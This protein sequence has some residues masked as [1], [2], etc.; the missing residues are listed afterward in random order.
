MRLPSHTATRSTVRNRS[1]AVPLYAALAA[2]AVLSACSS[3]SAWRS[4]S[5]MTSDRTGGKVAAAPASQAGTGTQGRTA[6][7]PA[8]GAQP[9]SA[10]GT[11]SS[12][13]QQQTTPPQR[14]AASAQAGDGGQAAHA[15]GEAETGGAGSRATGAAGASSQSADATTPGS[16]PEI[17]QANG[18]GAGGSAVSGDQSAEGAGGREALAS[19]DAARSDP[20]LAGSSLSGAQGS[21]HGNAAASAAGETG[22]GASATVTDDAA[23]GT[24]PAVQ[25]TEG[26]SGATAAGAAGETASGSTGA[27]LDPATTAATSP[28]TSGASEGGSALSREHA[29]QQDGGEARQDEIII[30]MVEAPGKKATPT[31]TV[32]PQTLGGML[33]LTLGVE[34]E[35]EF[36]FDK[37][38]V[39]DQVRVV[40]DE[41]A[42]KLKT[43]DYDRL[44]IIGHT[45]RIGTE[46]YNQ[47]L[48]ERR[49]WAVAR[50]L[51]E[52]GV[53]ANKVLVEGR[54]M[55]EPVTA[56]H[57]CE[58]LPREE[59]IACLQKD[60]RVVI[61]A[62]IRRVDVNVH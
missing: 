59:A 17:T 58:G 52:Q 42:S 61:S 2:A 37:A 31:E 4:S 22:T 8:A 50:Y 23:R 1:A 49:A 57:I 43:A 20:G 18:A 38:I 3:S 27:N 53:P 28:S 5:A 21:E 54:G 47:Y 7:S 12:A 32:I 55:H 15:A 11:T 25:A 14:G 60:R 39:R 9:S 56:A 30:G 6:P 29:W 44:E 34:G 45:D 35:G 48:S 10:D 33:P 46:S 24:S 16:A 51:I 26:T 36:D 41:L 19:T 62:S 13:A 40:L